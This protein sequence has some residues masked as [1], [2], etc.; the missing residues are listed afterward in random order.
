LFIGEWQG[1]AGKMGSFAPNW[2]QNKMQRY[3]ER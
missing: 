2:T 1:E 3:E